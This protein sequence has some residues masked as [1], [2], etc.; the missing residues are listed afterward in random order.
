MKY[1]VCIPYTGWKNYEVEAE[2]KEEAERKAF[3]ENDI[4][5]HISLCWHCADELDSELVIDE[6]EIYVEG[7]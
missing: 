4:S 7:E 2:S 1:T 5:D 6:N 3:E